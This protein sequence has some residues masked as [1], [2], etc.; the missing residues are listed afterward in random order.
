M[1][2]LDPMLQARS[3]A[4]VGASERTGSV[5][6][7]TVRQLLSGGFAGEVYPVN[8]R[9]DTI[10]GLR[11]LPS[12]DAVGRPVD[13]AVLAVGNDHLETEMEKA[14]RT[15]ARSVVIF[16]SCVG[17]SSAGGTL[18]NR[19]GALASEAGIP[20]CGGNGM[21]FLNIEDRVR[22]CGFY[23]PE[24]LK[25]GGVSFLSHSGSLFSAMLHN[26]RGIDFN[27][28]VST[29]LEINTTMDDYMHWALGLESTRVLALF[30]ETVRN[31]DGFRAALAEA[32][33]RD[34]PVV[35]LKVGASRRGG[36]AVATH[37]EAL[38]GDD[39]VHDALF[40][41]FG[42]HRVWSMDEM[43][44]TIELFAAGRRA[45]ASGLGAVH[46]SGGERAL[47]IDTADRLGVL[48]PALGKTATARLAAVLDPGLEPANPVDAWGTGR[49]AESV[50]VECLLALADDP[51]VGAVTFS[52][53]LTPEERPDDAYSNAV[54][55]VAAA[56]DKP[57][58]VLGNVATAL[59]PVQAARLRQGGI[60]VLEGTET[61]LRALRH[62]FDHHGHAGRPSLADRLSPPAELSAAPDGE[63]AALRLLSSYGIPVPRLETAR[64]EP[65]LLE[66]AAR[67]GY[68]VVLKTA[69]PIGH[70]ADVGGVILGIPGPGPLLDAYRG[71]SARL[72]ADVMV[73]EMIT[74]SVEIGLGMFRDEQFG[75]VIVLSA[76]GMLIELIG[77]RVALLPR[78]D[79]VGARRA[80][81]R[82]RIRAMLDGVRG[83]DPVDIDA[84]TEV[85]ARFSEL[86]EDWSDV[87]DAFDVNPVIAGPEGAVAVDA[88]IKARR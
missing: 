67:V 52:V 75:P 79:T 21:G 2:S 5:G 47:L 82:L 57:V 42:V 26:R 3:V 59:D 87:I 13:L 65:S 51:E 17:E 48:L 33:R 23:Q 64:D 20:I 41:M 71:L 61:G 81:D 12:L 88:L 86:A 28:V 40:D 38:A 84:V 36:E 22:I 77:D 50:F 74:G 66:A 35:A 69:G 14:V 49:D 37:S 27:L 72:G 8:P 46:D 10:H 6:D 80:L 39:A 78:V 11:A 73:S 7:Q 83:A 54:L 30:L 15:G 68:P 63:V 85:I 45:Q 76:G 31:P 9:H 4:I 18:R 1:M 58:T 56:T 32:E 55:A 60:P 25:P 53:D 19:L 16:A 62:L 70:K 44:D 34:I 29:G 24:T 43:A